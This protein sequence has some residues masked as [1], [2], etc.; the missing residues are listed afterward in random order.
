MTYRVRVDDKGT[1]YESESREDA[2]DQFIATTRLAVHPEGFATG[3]EVLLE[4]GTEVIA[5]WSPDNH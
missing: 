5:R 3:R 4:A 1:V 2:M